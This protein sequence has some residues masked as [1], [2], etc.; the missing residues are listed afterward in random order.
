MESIGFEFESQNEHLLAT[1]KG[2]SCKP[3][4]GKLILFISLTRHLFLWTEGDPVGRENTNQ[5]VWET[6]LLT[7]SPATGG[8]EVALETLVFFPT[9]RHS[10][11]LRAVARLREWAIT[12]RPRLCSVGLSPPLQVAR[13]GGSMYTLPVRCPQP[14]VILG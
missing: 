4:V 8:A 11:P 2:Q 10:S 1:E 9:R 6:W 7:L 12:Q 5:G 13:V 14:W 3:N